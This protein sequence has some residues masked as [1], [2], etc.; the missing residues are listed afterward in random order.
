MCLAIPPSR[1]ECFGPR[2]SKQANPTCGVSAL[3]IPGFTLAA[4]GCASPP[5]RPR[6][7]IKV[8]LTHFTLRE[9]TVKP[10]RRRPNRKKLIVS[11]KTS[12]KSHEAPEQTCARL[13][14]YPLAEVYPCPA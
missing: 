13:L 1:Q 5:M 10:R 9:K 3:S 6:S 12:G 7:S 4:R 14:Y 2:A 11:L 8:G